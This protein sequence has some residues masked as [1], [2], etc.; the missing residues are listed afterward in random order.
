MRRMDIVAG[1]AWYHVC[2]QALANKMNRPGTKKKKQTSEAFGQTDR[3]R[4]RVGEY[5][6][7]L[8][9][10]YYNYNSTTIT[11]WTNE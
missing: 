2:R 9:I 11:P 8:C 3:Q 10:H 4:R 5:S 7:R 1:L 6:S